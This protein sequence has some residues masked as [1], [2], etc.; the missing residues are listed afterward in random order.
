MPYAPG[1][2]YRGDQYI[3]R[4]FDA[5]AGGIKDWKQQR[6]QIDQGAKM[7][8]TALP[9]LKENNL[10]DPNMDTTDLSPKQKYQTVQ[11]MMGSTALVANAA[12]A[13]QAMQPE[14]PWQPAVETLPDGTKIFR[15][16]PNSAQLMTDR[17]ENP[18]LMGHKVGDRNGDFVFNGERWVIPSDQKGTAMAAMANAGFSADEIKSL[19]GS[20]G[21]VRPAAQAAPS[22]PGGGSGMSASA[23]APANDQP[24]KITTD[25][26]YTALP[27]GALFID[28]ENGKTYR[29][30]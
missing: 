9:M 29:K 7:F 6:K 24:V 30:P 1:V 12:K 2:Q 16:S 25:A 17:P 15:S 23:P 8:D 28:P 22:A 10:I 27:S 14:H 4:G 26:E 3:S 20:N 5:L 21:T 18:N 19:L 11:A 13:R